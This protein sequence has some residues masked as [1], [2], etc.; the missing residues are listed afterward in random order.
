MLVRLA[1]ETDLAGF[2]QEAR[3][4]LARGVP[5]SEVVWAAESGQDDL[6]AEDVPAPAG[7]PRAAAVTVSVPAAFLEL[8]N[9]VV[10]HIDPQRFALLYRL[11]WRLAR[12]PG[13]RHDPLDADM[14]QARQLAQSVRRDIHKMHAFVRFRTVADDD[15]SG[16][17][18]HVAWFE[19]EH[20]IVEA[21]APWFKRRF[22]NMRWAILTP[23][24][25]VA[26]D[27]RELHFLPG[28]GRDAAPP[29]DAGEQLWL[30]YYQSIFNP[31]RLKLRMMQQEMP[32]KYWRNLPEAQLIAPL[33]AQAQE[34]SGRML[35]APAT[36]PLKRIPLFAAVP[37]APAGPGLPALNEAMQACRACPLGATATQ[38]VP[39]EGPL[40]PGLMFVGEQPGDQEDLRG[41][42]FVGPAGQLLD[43]AFTQAGIARQEIFVTN[44]VRHFSFELRGKRR[45]HKTPQQ[46]EADAC[47][48]WLEHEI[49][50]VQPRAL[51]ALGATAA[52][53]LLGRAVPVLKERG[54]W[55][56]RGDGLQVLVTL[57]PSALLRMPSEQLPAAFD[58]FVGDLR[59]AAAGPAPVA[60]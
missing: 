8:C 51:V 33:A 14:L 5:P 4:L 52:R 43:R 36:I 19:P 6:F 2:R 23:R 44:A 31:A 17:P 21:N 47:R 25:C 39:G 46:Q 41:R 11:L 55:H 40:Q 18:L 9:T 16:E 1:S 15:P 10:L 48:H 27:R 7:E 42:P 12:E 37:Q 26:W 54:T 58:A 3:A 45:I 60:G 35:E 49:A 57:H 56:A 22:A 29:P 50:Q 28:A 53:A 20:H 24:R 38:A 34:R 30:T 32:R 13:L 59:R